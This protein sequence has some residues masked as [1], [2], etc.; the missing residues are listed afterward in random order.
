MQKQEKKSKHWGFNKLTLL[1]YIHTHTKL[2]DTSTEKKIGCSA[3]YPLKTPNTQ[4][5]DKSLCVS[6]SGRN[7]GQSGE[8]LNILEKPLT[9]RNFNTSVWVWNVKIKSNFVMHKTLRGDT[10]SSRPF[11]P[12][13]EVT[14]TEDEGVRSASKPCGY[15]GSGSR[16]GGGVRD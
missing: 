16:R 8:V 11:G 6:P 3:K 7:K 14:G 4:P 5:F 10:L 13:R 9:L 1:H 12:A 15:E 2:Y